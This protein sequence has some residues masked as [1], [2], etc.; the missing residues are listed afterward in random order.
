MAGCGCSKGSCGCLFTGD[1]IEV[2]GFGSATSPYV[3]TPGATVN[4]VPTNGQNIAVAVGTRT[5]SLAPAGTIATL[6]LTLPATTTAFDS[7]V[8][9]FTTATITAL[10][11]AADGGATVAGAPTTLAANGFFRMKKIGTVW[12]RV[13]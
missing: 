12:H 9:V 11:V 8:V 10:T 2:T 4:V 3:I 5:E 13:G 6:T 7:E 1:G